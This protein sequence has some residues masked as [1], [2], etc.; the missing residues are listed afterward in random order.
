M[1]VY[2]PVPM[3]CVPAS[4]STVPPGCRRASAVAGLRWAG[5]TEVAMPHPISVWPS[6]SVPGR[7]GRRAQPNRSAPM[8]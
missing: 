5:Y 4:T 7:T 8:R 6:R 1:M 3:S 2:V